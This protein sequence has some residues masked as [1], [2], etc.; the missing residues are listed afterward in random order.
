[1]PE[2]PTRRR[3]R[4]S[5]RH[6]VSLPLASPVLVERQVRPDPQDPQGQLVRLDR[7]DQLEQR[8]RQGQRELWEVMRTHLPPQDSLNPQQAVRWRY[9]LRARHGWS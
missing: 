4:R 3:A 5:E 2:G 9:R 1:M 6:Q 7:R 8:D